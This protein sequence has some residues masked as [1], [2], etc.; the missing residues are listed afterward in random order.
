MTDLLG[1]LDLRLSPLGAQQVKMFG[2]VC[3]MLNG[4][5]ALGTFR[6]GML[7]RVGPHNHDT[8]A[9]RPGASPM[10]MRDKTMAGY[11]IVDEAALADPDTLESWIEMA[12]AFNRTLPPKAAKKRTR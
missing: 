3:F 12:L 7:V 6:N 4:N 9:A 1:K 8:A 11:I 5:M 2:G 10:V